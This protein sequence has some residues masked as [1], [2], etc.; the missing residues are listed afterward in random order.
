M[1]LLKTLVSAKAVQAAVDYLDS[2]N[3]TPEYIP[4]GKPATRGRNAGLAMAAT[5]I[6]RRNPRL[7][8]TVGAGALLVLAA[9]YW[10]K[11]KQGKPY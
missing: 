3:R 9:G 10:V 8:G 11:M 5:Q 4:A 7:L 1:G 2:K 6:V